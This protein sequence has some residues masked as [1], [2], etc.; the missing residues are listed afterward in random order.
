[1]TKRGGAVF[2][3]LMT[4]AGALSG[5]AF[6]AEP[7]NEEHSLILNRYHLKDPPDLSGEGLKW[8]AKAK[9]Y[10]RID[11]NDTTKIT[12]DQLRAAIEKTI[13]GRHK[14]AH[15]RELVENLAKTLPEAGDQIKDLDEQ[16]LR[17][18]SAILQNHPRLIEQFKDKENFGRI[19]NFVGRIKDNRSA[20]DELSHHFEN[21]AVH[22]VRPV[23]PDDLPR[24]RQIDNYWHGNG[25]PISSFFAHE[26]NRAHEPGLKTHEPP[27]PSF[28]M[29][30]AAVVSP[31]SSPFELSTDSIGHWLKSKKP[32][33][34]ARI[35]QHLLTMSSFEDESTRDK[36]L[37]LLSQLHDPALTDTFL[38][39]LDAP[40]GQAKEISARAL[41]SILGTLSVKDDKWKTYIA[42][43]PGLLQRIATAPG[44]S[45][46]WELNKVLINNLSHLNLM[47]PDQRA[48]FLSK[49]DNPQAIINM[50]AATSSNG[51]VNEQYG[52]HSDMGAQLFQQFLKAA[53]GKG[54][55]EYL[56]VA[57]ED[58]SVG[59]LRL[60][61]RLN[62][63]GVLAGELA[64]DPAL[65]HKVTSL[66]FPYRSNTLQPHETF[67]LAKALTA[68][69]GPEFGRDLL[70]R[71]EGGRDRTFDPTAALLYLALH[72]QDL[73]PA[74][75][76]RVQE[77]SQTVLEPN[78]I[79]GLSN[80]ANAAYYSKWPQT[81]PL[82]VAGLMVD[83]GPHVKDFM[84][85]LTAREGYRLA[86][87]T[88]ENGF[89]RHVFVNVRTGGQPVHLQLDVFPADAKGWAPG[90]ALTREMEARMKDSTFP[91][92]FYR[93]H[94]ADYAWNGQANTLI[95]RRLTHEQQEARFNEVRQQYAK[96]QAGMPEGRFFMDLGCESSAWAEYL[97]KNC[98]TC[99]TL[100]LTAAGEGRHNNLL[101]PAMIRAF[102]QRQTHDQIQA[103]IRQI[104][105]G[106][107]NRIAG[108]PWAMAWW[109]RY[110]GRANADFQPI[111]ARVPD[112]DPTP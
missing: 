27:A 78:I 77:I 54:L 31:E 34:L 100:G 23:A 5:P 11:A 108:S 21:S 33:D 93:G 73:D 13:A 46:N 82:K 10:Q 26:D 86:R 16:Q 17:F 32:E 7:A 85:Q 99:G 80:R 43:G 103:T 104:I 90:P 75:K 110:A 47:S 51:P 20:L 9:E 44:A 60:V 101:A 2:L 112:P 55:S 50:F 79:T 59:S 63:Y 105:P 107:S 48:A 88:P 35:K 102:A 40:S 83:Q 56:C 58:C 94:V 22:G 30:T 67:T 109:A 24:L 106:Y 42:E 72:P 70:K 62:R 15:R 1:M 111:W 66:M 3:A 64:K 81:G 98:P 28:G 19:L 12:P 52:L 37:L 29:L 97:I 92:L 74:T 96:L 18:V 76:T 6:A 36:A 89:T 25:S 49:L 61:A 69:R 95:G 4:W 65:V 41:G 68:A 57:N 39:H 8:D 14:D 91:V 84:T 38:K 45:G 53:K 87:T 71:I